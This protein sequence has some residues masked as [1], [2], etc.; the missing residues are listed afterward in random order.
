MQEKHHKKY[1]NNYPAAKGFHTNMVKYLDEYT[2][3]NLLVKADGETFSHHPIIHQFLAFLF[4]AHL[5]TDISEI[6]VAMA[7]SK[8][9]AYYTFHN[10]ETISKTEIKK[11]LSGYFTFIYGKYGIKNEKLMKG[12]VYK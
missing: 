3:H 4:G 5:I 2:E 9:F 12:F 11:I 6:T 8:F 10:E 7:N 1:L